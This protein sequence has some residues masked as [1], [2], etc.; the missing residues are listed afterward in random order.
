VSNLE[1]RRVFTI[2]L[3]FLC[4]S[5]PLVSHDVAEM[6]IAL[7]ILL[8]LPLGEISRPIPSVTPET[9]VEREFNKRT[10]ELGKPDR[11]TPE[12]KLMLLVGILDR[13]S[14]EE[15][16]TEFRRLERATATVKGSIES[17]RM[18]E[19]L[20]AQAFVFRATRDNDP[21]MLE[22]TLSAGCPTAIV[23]VPI[24]LFLATEKKPELFRVLF[25][26]FEDAAN[27]N[28]RVCIV[29]CLSRGFPEL[30]KIKPNDQE[31]VAACSE[32]WE[33]NWE[34]YK[35]NREYP[36]RPSAPFRNGPSSLFVK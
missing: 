34:L 35:V 1:W 10:A 27:E 11:G 14:E 24:E 9:N 16:A 31:F 29:S 28:A 21:K 4:F 25:R 2:Q 13:T 18:F 15:R 3:I 23:S 19:S 32:W 33:K 26:S 22:K 8:M 30:R 12:R 7:L 5:G 17:P 6:K 36:Y 20:L